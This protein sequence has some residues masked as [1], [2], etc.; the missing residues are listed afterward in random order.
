MR[1]CRDCSPRS[2]RAV[3]MVRSHVYGHATLHVG[4]SWWRHRVCGIFWNFLGFFL[5]RTLCLLC[6]RMA[7]LLSRVDTSRFHDS[8]PCLWPPNV[9]CG[10]RSM[11]SSLVPF[12][13]FFW[14]FFLLVFSTWLWR[15]R[16]PGRNSARSHM[17]SPS[18]CPRSINMHG[19]GMHIILELFL[20]FFLCVSW[21]R[22]HVFRHDLL[23]I[24]LEMAA[25][26]S[27]F[28]LQHWHSHRITTG[29]FS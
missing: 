14:I 28:I 21:C 1:A 18:P 15:D 11:T 19:I 25:R 12:F 22:D 20:N 26:Q 27:V 4:S 23:L 7:R 13:A 3:F 9:A 24:A 8:S 10:S 6:A 2:I 17:L 29:S 5:Y 16:F